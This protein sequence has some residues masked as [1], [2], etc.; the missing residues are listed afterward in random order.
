MLKTKNYLNMFL[1]SEQQELLLEEYN[2]SALYNI[3]DLTSSEMIELISEC[4]FKVRILKPLNYMELR[5][6]SEVD[7]CEA[8]ADHLGLPVDI[9]DDQIV[10][11]DLSGEHMYGYMDFLSLYCDYKQI[12][13]STRYALE[14]QQKANLGDIEFERFNSLHQLIDRLEIYWDDY[15][16]AFTDTPLVEIVNEAYDE[17]TT[18][19]DSNRYYHKIMDLLA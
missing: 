12:L 4:D 16:I 15:E 17:S 8:L 7:M 9:M 11:T 2:I 18:Q 3:A 1:S 10:V 5:D 6:M 14:D 13:Q 19:V